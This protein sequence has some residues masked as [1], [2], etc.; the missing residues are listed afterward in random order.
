MLYAT[1]VMDAGKSPS[2]RRLT[3]K[4]AAKRLNVS[5]AAIRQRLQRGSIAHEKD[6]ETN[7]V[8][9]LIDEDLL[10]DDGLGDGETPYETGY[11]R[12]LIDT[13]REQLAAEREANRENRRIIAALASRIPEIEAPTEPRES[14]LSDEGETYGSPQE[15]E[16]SLHRQHKRSWWRA[17]FGLE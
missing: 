5:E 4:D 14:P 2:N 10:G 17:F 1:T 13:L 6:E 11:E 9:V 8:Y 7:R 16:D 3:V 12:E 15:A